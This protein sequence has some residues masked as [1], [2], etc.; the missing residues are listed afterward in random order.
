[1]ND[2]SIIYYVG[3]VNADDSQMF[4]D[5]PYHSLSEAIR[6]AGN[7]Y[8]TRWDESKNFRPM[9]GIVKTQSG[10]IAHVGKWPMH[11]GGLWIC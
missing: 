4:E 8:D 2:R 9:H 10:E 6:K 1:M 5:M 3:Y 7:Y 11:S